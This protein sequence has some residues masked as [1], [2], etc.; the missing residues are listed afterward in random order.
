MQVKGDGAKSKAQWFLALGTN[1]KPAPDTQQYGRQACTINQKSHSI[2]H[3]RAAAARA[4]SSAFTSR[5]FS[6]FSRLA[7]DRQYTRNTFW[8]G[9]EQVDVKGT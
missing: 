5:T 1:G 4:S 3:S 2:T 6:S 8:A 7:S 9:G